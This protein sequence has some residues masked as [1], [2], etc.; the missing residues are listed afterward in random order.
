LLV[1]ADADR[2]GGEWSILTRDDG[3]QQWAYDGYALYTSIL[4]KQPGDVLGATHRKAK[5]DAPGVREP[6][7]PPVAI[8]PQ[9]SVFQVASG[10]LLTDHRAY[11]VYYWDKD[12]K[13]KSNCDAAC[14]RE[15]SPVLAPEFAQTKGDWA[16][17][18]RSPGVKQWSFRG[19]PLYTR[20][21]DETFRS[22]EGSDVPGWHNAYTQ[23]APAPPKEFTVQDTRSGQVLADAHGKTI[24]VYNCGDDA[25]DQLACDNPD[26]TQAYRFAICGGGDPAT[27]NKT[28]PM[29][30]AAA[31]AKSDSRIWST[32]DID[33]ATGHRA[34]PDTPNAK[35]VWAYRGRPVY[36]F[37]GDHEPGDVEGDAWGEFNAWR[38]GFKAFWLR[39]D[40]RDNAG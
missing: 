29:V 20:K 37:A 15:W 17:F 1:T 9:F 23:K 40:F 36:T 33:P 22:L 35:H 31:N 28:W 34:A 7:S 8:P 4:D 39:D 21:A 3:A 32:M 16:I 25:L 5:G 27:C 14:L 38:D 19:H 30:P 2:A 13:N 12:G 6:V 10:R 24:Y 18:E 11:S 26:T